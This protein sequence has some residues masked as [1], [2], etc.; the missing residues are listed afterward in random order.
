M[1]SLMIL[2]VTAFIT[3]SNNSVNAQEVTPLQVVEVTDARIVLDGMVGGRWSLFAGRE[4]ANLNGVIELVNRRTQKIYAVPVV[5][6]V[7]FLGIDGGLDAVINKV[8]TLDAFNGK[9]VRALLG[10]YNGVEVAVKGIGARVLTLTNRDR[11]GLKDVSFLVGLVPG[12]SVSK[13]KMRVELD[14][15]NLNSIS[16]ELSEDTVVQLVRY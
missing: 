5:L 1:K 14:G 4:F 7:R 15:A 9:S 3:F 10:T 12:F 11:V 8:L 16:K 2:A 13:Y 6:H